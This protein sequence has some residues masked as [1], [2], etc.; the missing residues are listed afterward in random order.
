MIGSDGARP[1]PAG[2]GPGG[3]PLPGGFNWSGKTSLK[4]LLTPAVNPVRT[5]PDLT[6]TFTLQQDYMPPLQSK[7]EERDKEARGGREK[8]LEGMD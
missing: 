1:G 3:G 2:G 5:T 6:H 7:Y 8:T 4:G